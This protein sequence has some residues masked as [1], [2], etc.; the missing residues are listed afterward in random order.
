MDAPSPRA[1]GSGRDLTG[2][3]KDG[4][5]FPV[6]I[7]LCAVTTDRGDKICAAVIDITERKRSEHRLR[8]AN[9][10]LEEFSYVAAHDLRSPVRGIANLVDFILEDYGDSA[11]DGLIVNIK[12]IRDRVASMERL[13]ED[14]LSYARSGKHTTKLEPIDLGA[15]IEEICL[16]NP[17]PEGAHLALGLASQPF[18][19]AR[20]PLLTT[21]RNLFANA[22]KHHDKDRMS[23]AIKSRDEGDYVVIDVADDGPGIPEAAH[24]RVFKLFQTLS[25]SEKKG[26]GLG[27]AVAQRL[28]SGHGGRLHLV[29]TDGV[30]GCTFRIWWPRF[31]RSDLDD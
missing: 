7:G 26:S 29:S 14:L 31:K 27:L 4:V 3:R 13:I 17:P 10:Q 28:V 21:I 23:I 30:R 12:R 6:E 16:T 25:S 20:T 11:P 5:E 18:E 19:G 24:E 22:V 1:M 15:M 8:E 2:R 9:A